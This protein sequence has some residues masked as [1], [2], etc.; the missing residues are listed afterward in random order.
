MRATDSQISACIGAKK[1]SRSPASDAALR[2]V[3]SALSSERKDPSSG[4]NKF[5]R[6]CSRQ[7]RFTNG[8]GFYEKHQL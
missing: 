6:I 7:R 3:D 4:G 8:E 2:G 1:K 5:N